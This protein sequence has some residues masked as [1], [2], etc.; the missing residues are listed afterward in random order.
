MNF[1]HQ[2]YIIFKMLVH[3][4]PQ[5]GVLIC[6]HDP[7]IKAISNV[8]EPSGVGSEHEDFTSRLTTRLMDDDDPDWN[9]LDY[10]NVT[11]YFTYDFTLEELKVGI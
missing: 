10:G 3:F 7:W 9:W 6:S 2:N 8:A 11:D 4:V 5:D 1:N